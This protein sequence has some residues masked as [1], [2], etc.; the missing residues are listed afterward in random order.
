[1]QTFTFGHL[2]DMDMF[3]ERTHADTVR[4]NSRKGLGPS[5]SSE[6][7]QACGARLELRINKGINHEKTFEYV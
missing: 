1:M 7:L 5:Q 2:A 4:T 6:S 3:L